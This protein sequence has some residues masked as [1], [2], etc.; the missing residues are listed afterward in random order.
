MSAAKGGKFFFAN[1][2]DSLKLTGLTVVHPCPAD[3]I[4]H[5]LLGIFYAESLQALQVIKLNAKRY[6]LFSRFPVAKM[7]FGKVLDFGYIRKINILAK[8][9]NSFVSCFFVIIKQ[10]I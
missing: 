4:I 3:Y 1:L 6:S 2:S 7:S 5:S 8:F 9:C 10:P